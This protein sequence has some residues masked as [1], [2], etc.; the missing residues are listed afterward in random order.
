MSEE[1]LPMHKDCKNFQRSDTPPGGK[2]KIKPGK[3]I[4]PR[5]PPC[6]NFE[7]EE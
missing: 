2:C 1:K 5:G 6:K 4:H 7:K 3:K